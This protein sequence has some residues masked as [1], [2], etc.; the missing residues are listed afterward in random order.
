MNETHWLI[1]RRIEKRWRHIWH[2]KTPSMSLTHEEYGLECR[3]LWGVSILWLF[4]NDLSISFPNK[5]RFE[6]TWLGS[7]DPPGPQWSSPDLHLIVDWEELGHI[8]HDLCCWVRWAPFWWLPSSFLS[9]SGDLLDTIL[10]VWDPR[11]FAVLDLLHF[12]HCWLRSHWSPRL[13]AW[14]R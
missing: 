6:L 10:E 8:L 4:V 5:S 3:H 12:D 11:A 2:T 13:L 9:N 7:Y 1:N 14:V